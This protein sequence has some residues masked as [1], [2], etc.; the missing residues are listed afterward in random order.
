MLENLQDVL[1]EGPCRDAFDLGEPVE[2]ALDLSATGRWPQFIPAAKTVIG[3][4]G[5]LWC[6]PMH[7]GGDV[8]GAV[9][10]YRRLPGPLV[11]PLDA[12]QTLADAAAAALI[13][14]RWHSPPTRPRPNPSAGHH[15]PR[16]TRRPE[17]WPAGSTSASRSL[18]LLRS[19]AFTAGIE[20]AEVAAAVVEPQT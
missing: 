6:M 14:N 7:A 16:S 15:G 4:N 10:M 17:C 1:G 18:A 9:S 8:I 13:R 12:A 11:E 5:V 2:T 19:H 20:L 3:R